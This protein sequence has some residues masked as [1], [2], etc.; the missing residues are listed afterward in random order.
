MTSNCASA[1][2]AIVQFSKRTGDAM[3]AS[4]VGALN[5]IYAD[6]WVSVDSHGKV[7]TKE[8]LL[9]DFAS[10]NHRLVSFELGSMKV[11]VLGDVAMAQASVT[12][13][14]I[15]DGKDV[16]GEFV[17]MDLLKRRGQDWTIVRT[18]GARVN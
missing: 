18:L 2:D 5:Q 1:I 17:F 8:N 16:S 7:F 6:D 13:K 4:D 9:S 14:R 10:G 15:Q 12:E 11:Q 3:V